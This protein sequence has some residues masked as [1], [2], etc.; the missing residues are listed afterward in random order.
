MNYQTKNTNPDRMVWTNETD[1]AAKA[2]TVKR[3]PT[4]SWLRDDNK[5]SWVKTVGEQVAHVLGPVFGE[6][7]TVGLK[8]PDTEDARKRWLRTLTLSDVSCWGG[9]LFLRNHFDLRFHFPI[10]VFL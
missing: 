1:D 10:R 4:A 9:W 3:I 5:D 6:G 2:A 8:L 7:L